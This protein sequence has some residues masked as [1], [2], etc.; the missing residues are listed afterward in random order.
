MAE[1]LYEKLTNHLLGK[2]IP[3][4]R[5]TVYEGL[6]HLFLMEDPDTFNADVQ[7]FIQETSSNQQ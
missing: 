3:Q 5:L 7:R 4:A 2:R 1:S 6:G